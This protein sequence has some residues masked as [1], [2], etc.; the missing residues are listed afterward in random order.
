M[1]REKRFVKAAFYIKPVNKTSLFKK[2]LYIFYMPVIKERDRPCRRW[3]ERVKETINIL[4]MKH[5]S[6][7][8]QGLLLLHSMCNRELGE[9]RLT[10]ANFCK[11]K[12]LAFSDIPIHPLVLDNVPV[13]MTCHSCRT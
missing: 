13:E 11:K 7:F 10:Y 3:R 9:T 12:E 1:Y 5:I 6:Q 4:Y 2:L 8:D